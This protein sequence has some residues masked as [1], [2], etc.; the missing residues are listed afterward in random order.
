MK[1]VIPIFIFLIIITSFELIAQDSL[2]VPR[3]NY[4]N[5]DTNDVE[6]VILNSFNPE[7]PPPSKMIEQKAS[8]DSIESFLKDTYPNIFYE[9]NGIYTFKLYDG[10]EVKVQNHRSEDIKENQSYSFIDIKCNMAL[11][12]ISGYESWGWLCVNLENGLTIFTLGTPNFKD[13]ESIF[14]A[15]NYYGEAEMTIAYLNEKKQITILYD[16][17]MYVNNFTLG[18]NTYYLSLKKMNNN[19][20][21]IIRIKIN[22]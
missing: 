4:V 6:I 16:N 20:F 14:A 18:D 17:W 21:K 15:D 10:K 12:K 1:N 11:I 5:I 3:I 7:I 19:Y 13:C 2:L 22:K 8:S 9:I